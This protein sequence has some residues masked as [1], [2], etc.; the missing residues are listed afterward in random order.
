MKLWERLIQARLRQITSIGNTQYGF[1]PGKSTTEPVFIMRIIH[2]K[3]RKMNKE[4]H[5]VFVIGVRDGGGGRGAPQFG[6]FA[7][8]NSGREAK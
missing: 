8:I 4:L 7:D 2:E 6:E 5:M 3:Y 1:R